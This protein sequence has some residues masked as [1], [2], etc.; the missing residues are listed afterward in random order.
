MTRRKVMV[1]TASRADYSR[2]RSIL[3]AIRKIAGL[4]LQL[5]VAGAH[6]LERFGNSVRDIEDDGFEIQEK[7]F[8]N[9][10]GENLVTMTKSTGYTIVELAST[11]DRLKPDIAL[12]MGDRFEAL[13]FA[14]AAALMNVQI[15]HVQGGEITGTIDESLRHAI[16]KL[17]HFHFPSTTESADRITR[18]GEKPD[19]IYNVGCPAVDTLLSFDIGT[20]S[21]AF[22]S[23]IPFIKILKRPKIEEPFLLVL[24]HPVT[25]EY[26]SVQDQIKQILYSISES[27]IQTIMLWPNLDAGSDEISI[28]IR[29][30]LAKNPIDNLFMFKHF[31]MQVFAKLMAHADC[32][33]G[34][35]SAGIREACYFGTP[36]LDI[37][38][39]Q[40]GRERSA[41]VLWS[42]VVKETILEGITKQLNHGRY[43]KEYL[44]G[45]GNAGNRIAEVLAKIEFDTAQKQIFY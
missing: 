26:G 44:Y 36:V 41:N 34:N 15:A 45:T 29:H 27:G 22:D 25:T 24:F 10:E 35:S 33:I 32:M 1:M 23:L 30:Y 3:F 17:S 16:T 9:L 18:M 7:I 37:G 5:V 21:E 14:T 2:Y 39:R 40:Q 12:V 6:L 31:S 19:N 8:Q 42:P 13:A 4:E 28:G 38:S 20:R 11:I 43:E